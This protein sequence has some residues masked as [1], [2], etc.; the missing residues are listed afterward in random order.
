M[1][2]FVVTVDIERPPEVV[3]QALLRA[4][5]AAQW[6]KD[7]VEFEVVS[8]EPGMV[9]SKGRLHYVQGGKDHFMEDV[10]EQAEPGRRYVSRVSGPAVTA[11][12]ETRIEPVEGGT[13]LTIEW[14]GEG[15]KLLPRLLLPLMRRRMV[16]RSREELETFKGLVETRGADFSERRGPP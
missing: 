2:R 12:V 5:N 11:R 7:L 13:R 4:D 6:N 1:V 3:D 9:G 10:M 14:T 15:V 16:R 8:G